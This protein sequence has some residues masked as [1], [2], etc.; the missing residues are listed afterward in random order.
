MTLRD[1]IEAAVLFVI[2]FAVA[3]GGVVLATL[4]GWG[5]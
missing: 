5:V 4:R 1:W 3:F 2:S